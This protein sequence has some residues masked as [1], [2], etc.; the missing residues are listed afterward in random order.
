MWGQIRRAIEAQ[1]AFAETSPAT[2]ANATLAAQS[3][4]ALAY[5]TLREADS[6]ESLLTKTVAEYKRSLTITQ[7]QYNAGSIDWFQRRRGR[8]YS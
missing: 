6:L 5:V 7:N 1:Q 3:L 2:L 8:R 4:L